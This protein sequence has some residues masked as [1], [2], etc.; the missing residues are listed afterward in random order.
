MLPVGVYEKDGKLHIHFGEV[1]FL[2]DTNINGDFMAS[3]IIMERIADTLP[4]YMK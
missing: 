4:S 2:N 1:Y 3:E